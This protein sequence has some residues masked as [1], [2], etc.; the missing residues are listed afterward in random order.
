MAILPMEIMLG[1]NPTLE[2]KRK[3]KPWG[4]NIAFIVFRSL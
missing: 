3:D 4:P 1:E 2:G